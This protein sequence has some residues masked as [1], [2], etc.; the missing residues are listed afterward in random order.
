[1]TTIN[2]LS[3]IDELSASDNIAVWQTKNGDSRRTS[4]NELQQY[5]QANLTFSEGVTT[6]RASPTV[7][8]FTISL[9]AI[10]DNIWLIMTPSG[11]LGI[12]TI[13]L[14]PTSSVADKQEVTVNCTE[15]IQFISIVADGSTGVFG[16]PVALTANEFFKMK[17]DETN[18][19]WY[20]VG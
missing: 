12:G 20:R 14:P 11:T 15:I 4:I 13:E 5:M 17:Y 19:A 8:E 3:F 7:T 10:S 18:D 9:P 16:A 6:Q 2:N 1:M